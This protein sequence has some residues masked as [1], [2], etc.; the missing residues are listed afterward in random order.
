VETGFPQAD[1]RDDFDRARR[2]A[3]WARLAGWLRGRPVARLEVL[4]EVAIAGSAGAGSP[5]ALGRRSG[6]L[7]R[8]GGD[9]L[10][11][12]GQIVGSVESSVPFDA[13]FRPT[14][15]LPRA[16]FERIAAAIRRGDGSDP[17]ELYRCGGRYFVNDGHH[18]IAVARALGQREVWAEVTDV[19]GGRTCIA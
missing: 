3:N 2:K 9:A 12:I 13:S 17:V 8:R 1:A 18:R 5:G 15:Q 14:S 11:P 16:R 10:V 6:G 4:G 19:R 7:S